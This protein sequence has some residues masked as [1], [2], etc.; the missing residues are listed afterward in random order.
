MKEQFKQ[1]LVEYQKAT[2]DK[3]QLLK[4]TLIKQMKENLIER[5]GGNEQY[6]IDGVKYSILSASYQQ[7]LIINGAMNAIESQKTLTKICDDER[8]KQ[9]NQKKYTSENPY[10]EE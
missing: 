9:M 7:L 4:E 2:I 6:S 5:N 8:E 1:L 3:D 10:H